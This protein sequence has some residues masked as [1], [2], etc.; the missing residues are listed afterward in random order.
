[1]I[2]RGYLFNTWISDLYA[3]PTAETL[4][5]DV[6]SS[7]SFDCSSSETSSKSSPI[8]SS[9]VVL[10]LFF[11]FSE[12]LTSRADQ[13]WRQCQ[14]KRLRGQHRQRSEPWRGSGFPRM[15]FLSLLDHQ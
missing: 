5:C 6:T 15:S 12:I 3:L 13:G 7:P 10:S 9:G 8:S 11:L 2:K 1:M 14:R 4:L